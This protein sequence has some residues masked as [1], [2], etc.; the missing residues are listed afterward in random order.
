LP[1]SIWWNSF[2]EDYNV[3]SKRMADATWWQSSYGLWPGVQ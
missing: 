1:G 3:K 2:A